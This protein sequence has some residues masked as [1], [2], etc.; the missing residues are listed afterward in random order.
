[1]SGILVRLRLV[2]KLWFTSVYPIMLMLVIPVAAYLI[3]ISQSYT[4]NSLSSMIYEKAAVILF[5][6]ILQWCLSIDFD[7]KFYKQIMT[8]PVSRWRLIIEKSLFSTMLF[9]GL[10][11]V[12]TIMLMPFVDS[13]IW[14]A[15]LFSVPVYIGIGGLVVVATVI[16]NHS[17]GG[18]FVGLVFWLISLSNGE[19]LLYLNPILL[20]FPNVYHFANGES[21]F[22]LD[23]NR[24]IIYNRLFY[25]GIGI[26]LTGLAMYQF[27]RKT[28]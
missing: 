14:K 25:L 7:S 3:Y 18:L 8:Y 13:F 1:M 27:H 19:L 24:W 17:L 5:V 28:V 23:E 20:D 22:F 9:W 12:I 4:V 10:L 11:L 15:L 21:G 2:L 26:L 16:G 6:F